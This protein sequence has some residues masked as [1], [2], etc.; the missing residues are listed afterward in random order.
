M[1]DR[2]TPELARLHAYVDGQLED[3][4][5]HDVEIS[6]ADNTEARER[7]QDYQR[8]NELLRQ[9][10][11]PILEEPVPPTLQ[12]FSRPPRRKPGRLVAQAAAAAILLSL[13]LMG[14]F[15]L[16][17]NQNLVP[18]TAEREADHAVTE[19]VVAYTVY[20]PEVRHP[21]EVSGDQRDHLVSWL[22]KRMGR[23]IIAPHLEN[24]D[25]RLLGGRLLASEDGPGA[26]LMYEDP[27]GRRIVIH[28]CLSDGKS[29][30]FHYARQSGVSVYYWVDDAVSYAVAGELD[31]ERLRP[32][33]ESVYNQ[34][35]F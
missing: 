8:M 27:Q 10:Y 14:G 9:L 16:G 29:S 21:V 35:V 31:K 30:A 33:A 4:I 11:D 2:L 20:S 22:S 6:L 3:D 23:N 1:N 19:A 18:M 32:L 25:M 34:L 5:R 26:L 28:A 7:V 12:R 15:Y 13:G 24:L 17:L